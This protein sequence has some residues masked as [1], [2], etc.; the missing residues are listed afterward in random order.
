MPIAFITGGA[1]AIGRASARALARD[2]W[3]VV[4]ADIDGDELHRVA[5]DLGETAVA[6]AFAL[7]VT[8]FDAVNGAVQKA[9]ETNGGLQGLVTAAGGLRYIPGAKGAPFSDTTPESWDKLIEVHLNAVYYT[10][11]AALPIFFRCGGGAIVNIASGAGLRGGPPQI[12]QRNASVY[13]A[14]KA[15]VIALT[16]SLAQESAAQGVR[17]NCVAPGRVESRDKSWEEMERMQREESGARL[18]PLGRFGRA[19]EVADAVAFLMSERAAYI[20]G[21]CLDIS[22]GSRL[23]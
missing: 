22:G 12:R 9:A 4:L 20:T 15:G 5:A 16:Q 2:G 7:D 18:P 14:A 1:G 21:V 11:H 3:R 13:S 17:A 23:H 6:G 8:D 10:C 19:R